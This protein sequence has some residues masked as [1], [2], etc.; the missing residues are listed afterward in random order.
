MKARRIL[1]GAL[2]LF[3]AGSAV[4]VSAATPGKAPLPATTAAPAA[5]PVPVET[6]TPLA[7][8]SPGGSPAAGPTTSPDPAATAAAPAGVGASPAIRFPFPLAS[9]GAIAPYAT[10]AKGAER[11]TGLIDLLRKDEE[12]YFDLSTETLGKTYIIAPSLA[13]GVGPG[14]FAGKIYDPIV[15]TF[16]RVGKRILWI[17][18]N[19]HFTAVGTSAQASLAISVADSVMA[20]TPIVAEDV[21]RHRIVIAPTM[22]LTDFE[23]IGADLGRGI[24]PAAPAGLFILGARPSFSLDTARSFYSTIK[25]FP[26]N[27]EIS[28]QLTFTGPQN[29]LATVPDGRGFPIRVHYSIVELPKHDSTFVPRYSDDRVGYFVTARKTYGDDNRESPFE[30]FINRWNLRNGP[31][32]FYLTNE[33]PA[34]YKP[35]IRRALLNWND[36][37]AKIGYPHAIDVRD[38]PKDPNFDPDDARYTSVRWITSERSEFSAYSPSI[39]NPETG[40]ILRGEIVIEG[41]S[42]RAIKRGF[43]ETVVPTRGAPSARDG[44]PSRFAACDFADASLTQA[45][46]GMMAL[47]ARSNI[48]PAQKEKFAEDWLYSVVLHEAGHVFGLR[49]NFHGSSAFTYAQLHDKAFTRTHGI[50]G[51]V[52]DYNPV[53]LARSN[54]TQADYFQTRLGPYD[55]WA[56]EYGYRPFESAAT[57]TAEL[58]YLAKIAAR[59]TQPGLAYGTDEDATPPFGSDPRIV[60]F[61]LSSDPLRFAAEQFDLNN[62]LARKLDRSGRTYDQERA[63]FLT[64]LNN[65]V[66]VSLIATRYIGGIYTSRSHRGQPG[67]TPPFVSIP[68]AEQKRAFDLVAHNVLSSQ[69]FAF[70][71]QLLNDLGSSRYLHW[72]AANP[73]RRTDFPY[74]EVVAQ[75]QDIVIDEMFS[76]PSFQRISDQALK[77]KPGTTMSLADL[78]TW[79]QLAVFDDIASAGRMPITPSHREL[80]RRYADLLMQIASLPAGAMAQLSLTHDTQELARFEIADVQNRIARTLGGRIS[81]TATH[82]HL[83]DLNVRLSRALN[84]TMIRQI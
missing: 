17:L 50:S 49:H 67:G 82:A 34:Q 51:S 80:Q 65:E 21:E 7:S 74:Y 79:T 19:P 32:T 76:V 36:A 68:R 41:E 46:V 8:P 6:S 63:A 30:R 61:D 15:V 37:F 3:V 69:A 62:E 75:I 70:S 53:N 35:T 9:P 43:V 72:D 27:D 31:I 81:D 83:A 45:S 66:G 44:D 16:K 38:Q 23:G 5:T 29:A 4:G 54:E 2:A 20:S 52:M 57:S 26:N 84:A 73:F 18:P 58:P 22:F 39:V 60:A 40:Q 33:I 78:F 24:A 48:T 71:P 10:F 42:L 12:I 64:I 56:I 59:S 1:I 11:Q 13:S 47:A 55:F 25:A 28:A 77:S 14:A